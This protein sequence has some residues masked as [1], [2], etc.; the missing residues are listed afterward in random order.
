[1]CVSRE[2]KSFK[3]SV[4]SGQWS[5]VSGKWSVVS[6]KWSVVSGQWSVVSGQ[7]SVVSGKW[8]VVS[9]QRSAVSGQWS[10]VSQTPEES[11]EVIDRII[12][13]CQIFLST[14]SCHSGL[15]V[16]SCRALSVWSK[17]ILLRKEGSVC[18]AV[19]MEKTPLAE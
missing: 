7:W 18:Q 6:G 17:G 12:G 8:S 3:W 19:I 15:L 1:M 14:L 2:E 13:F 9:G 11:N 4:V 5:V 10:V 16:S